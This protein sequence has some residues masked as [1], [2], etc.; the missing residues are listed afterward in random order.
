MG[1]KQDM[2]ALVNTVKD[3]LIVQLLQSGV[4]QKNAR[5]IAKCDIKR[6]SAIGKVLPKKNG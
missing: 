1:D 2:E 3:M 6:V 4:S 5:A